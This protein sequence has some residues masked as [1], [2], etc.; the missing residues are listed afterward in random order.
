MKQIVYVVMFNN[1]VSR[2]FSTE[3]AAK[4]CVDKHNEI[5]AESVRQTGSRRP[6][7]WG[8]YPFTLDEE[9]SA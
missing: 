2:V 8:Y 1:C 9:S 7:F 5:E 4:A 3:A 6:V